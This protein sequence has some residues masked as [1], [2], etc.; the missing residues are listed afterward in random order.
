MAGKNTFVTI[1]TWG[2]IGVGAWWLYETFIAGSS[3]T[4]GSSG[5]N[6]GGTT[7]ATTSGSNTVASSG[8]T[9]TGNGGGS[10]S[11]PAGTIT[12]AFWAS[13]F[14]LLN[15]RVATAQQ[16][17]DPSVTLVGSTL[18]ASP[19]VFNYYFDQVFP[20]PP[21]NISY[22]G[23]AGWP[24]DVAQV[25]SGVDR[26]Q[27]MSIS[28]YWSGLSAYLASNSKGMSGLGVF[29]GLGMIASANRGWPE[30]ATK[31]W[32][33]GEWPATQGWWNGGAGRAVQ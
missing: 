19:D 2:A 29:A 10:S 8:G 15:L 6:A 11:T 17:G 5:S 20:S 4:A 16:Q 21:S 25:F 28:T 23:Q 24:P 27:P 26:T 14:N 3:A 22:S 12:A 9:D 13:L 32:N 33:G 1:L 18:T 30:I 7:A 31:P